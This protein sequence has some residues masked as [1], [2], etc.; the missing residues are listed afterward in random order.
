MKKL[1]GFWLNGNG[2]NTELRLD[3]DNDRH[4]AMKLEKGDSRDLVV[5]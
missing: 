1:D 4:H 3:F 2:K 5:K